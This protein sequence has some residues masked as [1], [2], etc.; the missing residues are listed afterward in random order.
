M[1]TSVTNARN[2]KKTGKLKLLKQKVRRYSIMDKYND[3]VIESLIKQNNELIE[4]LKEA[5]L[6][7]E[8][9]HEKFGETGS[10]NQVLSKI[11]S[12]IQKAEGK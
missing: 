10:G 7:I 9:L 11:Q 3:V 4:L 8:Y 12:A 2:I 1:Y 5:Q 6:Q